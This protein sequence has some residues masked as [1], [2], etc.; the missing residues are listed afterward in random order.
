MRESK[1]DSQR[2]L[3]VAPKAPPYGGIALQAQQLEALLRRDGIAVVF[4][5]SNLPFPEF[6]GFLDQIRGLR[7]FFRSLFFS[8]KLWRTLPQVEVVHILA[9]SWL[10]FFLIV[11]PAV[12]LSRLRGKR[13]I[14]NYRAGGS[15]PFFRRCRWLLKPI[16]TLSHVVTAPSPFL[17]EMIRTYFGVVP[18]I[19]AN[20]VDVSI[21]RYRE[22]QSVQP[23]MLVTRHLEK[24]YDVEAIIRAFRKVQDG[25]SEASLWI[26]GTGSE[27]PYLR[28]LVSTLDL[29]NV[30]FL[31]HVAHR[32]LP[33]IYDQCDILLNA[34]RVDNFPA[35]LIE[36]SAS[37]LVIVSTDAGGIPFIYQHGKTA[38]LVKP[39]DWEEL[40]SAVGEV[41][42]EPLLAR[43]LAREAAK[44][45]RQFEWKNVRCSLYEAYGF[46]AEEDQK[47]EQSV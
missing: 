23:R 21:F 16:F 42:R 7:P 4:L 39:G 24:A 1:F 12:I 28:S 18:L 10:Y 22:R 29:R 14:L 44:M 17:G 47:L 34:S 6:L 32:D 35:S 9:C 40:A 2:V 43:R 20:F 19:V 8:W 26:A 13:V 36:A 5:P 25:Y 3:L 11:Y 46:L 31:G 30:L 38:L 33:A 27:E 41:L 37:G 45:V 15:Q